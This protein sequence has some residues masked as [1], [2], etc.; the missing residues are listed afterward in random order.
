MRQ[1]IALLLCAAATLAGCATT[2]LPPTQAVPV[3]RERLLYAAPAGSDAHLVV[4]RDQG[5]MGAGCYY[6]LYINRNLAARLAPGEVARFAVPSGEVLLAAGR[7]PTGQGLCSSQI[8]TTYNQ[9]ET[10]L[11]PGQTKAFRLAIGVSGG[12]DVMPSDY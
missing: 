6:A 2:A 11:K 4:V 9:R 12:V 1:R 7:D 8:D 3:P 10:V 5:F